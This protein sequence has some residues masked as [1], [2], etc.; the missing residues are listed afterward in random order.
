VNKMKK[1]VAALATVAALVTSAAAHADFLYNL[2]STAQSGLPNFVL[3]VPALLTVSTAFALSDFDAI[4]LPGGDPVLSVSILNPLGAPEVNF[5]VQNGYFGFFWT[6]ANA[7]VGPGQYCAGTL[8]C[9]NTAAIMTIRDIGA[10][11]EPG[12]VALFGLGLAG[13]AA[14]RRRR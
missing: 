8:D 9:N 4:N 3:T 1:R 10:A 14:W 6:S 13:L 2:S 12:S 5:N 7:F 11:P